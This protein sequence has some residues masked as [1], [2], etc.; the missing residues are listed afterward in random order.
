MHKDRSSQS[1]FSLNLDSMQYF[2]CPTCGYDKAYHKMK[3]G[4]YMILYCKKCNQNKKER[5]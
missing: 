1:K 5:Q 2:M 4:R 3:D